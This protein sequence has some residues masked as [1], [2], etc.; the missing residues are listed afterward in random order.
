MDVDSLNTF[1]KWVV[2]TGE[3]KCADVVALSSIIMLESNRRLGP[4]Q[5]ATNRVKR[6]EA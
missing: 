1:N 3:S 2:D 6:N 5:G 4:L